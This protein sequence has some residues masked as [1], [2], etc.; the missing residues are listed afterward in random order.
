MPTNYGLAAQCQLRR[1]DFSE[2]FALVAGA[3]ADCAVPDE[4]SDSNCSSAVSQ[5]IPLRLWR[6]L[7]TGAH[8]R[9]LMLHT[10][11]RVSIPKSKQALLVHG[12]RHMN[13]S[14]RPGDSSSSGKQ[15]HYRVGCVVAVV[16]R[17]QSS[18]S[19]QATAAAANSEDTAALLS[20]WLLQINFGEAAEL[21]AAKY[22]SNEPFT[23]EE[24]L[25]YVRSCVSKCANAPVALSSTGETDVVARNVQDIHRFVEAVRSQR[26]EPSYSS[27]QQKTANS[28][29]GNTCHAKKR[30][31]AEPGAVGDGI[32]DSD[33][34]D[35]NE[36]GHGVVRGV[37][38]AVK[39]KQQA[40]LVEDQERRLVALRQHLNNKNDELRQILQEQKQAARD[41]AAQ[42]E[43]WN[44]KAEAQGLAMHRVEKELAEERAAKQLLQEKT[45]QLVTKMK[46]LAEQTR[47]YKS[48]SDTV[49]EWLCVT[50][51]KPED[52]L[53]RVQEKMAETKT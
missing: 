50:S 17:P 26:N 52:V 40:R 14:A 38:T 31:R 8:I 41:H 23:K 33:D 28:G 16:P 37:C 20:S 12:N 32:D 9:S 48:V 27:S 35:N 21:L 51:R 24:H 42:Q 7:L 47:K 46:C 39:C 1:E 30:F 2:L 34:D 19:R 36:N 11:V 22:V 3:E 49:A 45:D 5:S 10:L 15:Q 29:D 18:E 6:T 25:V 43:Q 44:A 53:E 4:L 13:S